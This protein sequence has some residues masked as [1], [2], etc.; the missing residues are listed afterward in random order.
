M[1][2]PWK[3]QGL[4]QAQKESG[5]GTARHFPVRHRLPFCIVDH[6]SQTL[7]HHR[8]CIFHPE[9][10]REPSFRNNATSEKRDPCPL[11]V[12]C[13]THNISNGGDT[14][15]TLVGGWAR[16]GGWGRR[17]AGP[18]HCPYE[19]HTGHDSVQAKHGP[20]IPVRLLVTEIMGRTVVIPPLRTLPAK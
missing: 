6:Q 19:T 10:S 7:T 1:G 17:L 15:S 3:R 12:L 5:T 18:C 2:E 16:I 13:Y 8:H 14:L 20:D 4:T 9:S 11:P